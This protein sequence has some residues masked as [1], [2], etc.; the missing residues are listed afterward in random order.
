M[1]EQPLRAGDRVFLC[2]RI[3][4]LIQG[5]KPEFRLGTLVSINP[6]LIY[7]YRIL[8]D[9]GHSAGYLPDYIIKCV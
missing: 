1:S 5:Y 3:F 9:D 6:S 7:C 4:K 2:S 8:W